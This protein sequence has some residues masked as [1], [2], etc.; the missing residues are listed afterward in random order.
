LAPNTKGRHNHLF[1]SVNLEAF[2]FLYFGAGFGKREWMGVAIASVALTVIV[3][4]IR[5]QWMSR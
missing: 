4:G 1:K 5:R 3:L 2:V